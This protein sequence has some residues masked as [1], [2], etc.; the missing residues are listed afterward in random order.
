MAMKQSGV[1]WIGD[2]PFDWGIRPVK[3]LYSLTTGFTPSSED[4]SLYDD[5][6]ETWVTISDL[7]TAVVNDSK[8]KISKEVADQHRKDLA[9]KGSLLYSFKLSVGTVAFAGKDLF[10]NE[11][12]A[13][14]QPLTNEA[15]LHYLRYASSLIVGNA[16][17]NIYGATIMNQKLINN[18]PLPVPP[19]VEQQ[20]IADYLDDRCS[21]IDEIIAEAT[22]SIEEYKGL[23]QAVIFEAVT[24]GL[25]KKIVF[26]TTTIEG[27]EEIPANWTIIKLKFLVSLIESGVSVNAGTEP[28]KDGE[29]GVLKTSSVSKMVFLSTENKNVNV[30]EYDRVKC[31]VKKNTIIVSRMNTP[32]LVGACGYVESDYR[33]IFL[34]DRLWQV[35]FNRAV[36]VKY[37]YYCLISSYIRDY[38]AS[39]ATGTSNSMQNISQGQFL[40]AQIPLPS[41]SEQR[42][43][44]TYLDC[45]LKEYD[46]LISEKQSL[47]DDLQAY[48]K[49]LIYEVV[50]GKRRVV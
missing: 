32:D 20:A 29:L 36:N 25:N 7:K 41:E 40:E 23:K 44:V 4:D 50:T 42:E 26:K 8:Q 27:I 17:T 35:H 31:P 33:N 15:S 2:V 13:A 28:A 22:A 47:I 19:Y 9:K 11:A 10:T 46:S 12:I 45:C 18:A 21:K 14:F 34:P 30:D 1:P 5:E 43:I 48:K 24:K 6:G 37:V 16:N 38:Y 3:A 39:L 49:S